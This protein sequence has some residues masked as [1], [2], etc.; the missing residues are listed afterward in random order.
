MARWSSLVDCQLKIFDLELLRTKNRSN[1]ELPP[2]KLIVSSSIVI[3]STNEK[4]MKA[5][6][7]KIA[8]FF[9]KILAI[10]ELIL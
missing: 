10:F 9:S 3:A 8:T 7:L 1:K 4:I 5:Q 2:S 6:N